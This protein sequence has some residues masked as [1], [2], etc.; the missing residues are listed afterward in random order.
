MNETRFSTFLREHKQILLLM[1]VMYIERIAVLC[2]LGPEYNLANDD[3]GYIGGGITF[4]A[5]G[6]V[7]IYQ[8]SPS[9]M[10]M[11]G[12]P[13]LL[14]L[15]TKLFGQARLYWV[16]VKLFWC[17]MGCITPFLVYKSVTLFAEKKYGLLA[18]AA[19]LLPNLA[20][21]DNVILTETPYYLCFTATIYCTLAMGRSRK[22]G[23]FAG[24]VIAYMAGLMLRPTIGIMPVFTAVYLLVKKF[25]FWQLLKRLVI[26]GLV[27][28]MFLVP[29]TVR[30]Y[31]HFDAFIPLTYGSG[32]PLLLGTYQGFGCPTDE[33]LDYE[34]N[35]E[36]VWREEYA[37]YLDEN[38][39][40]LDDGMKQYLTLEKDGIKAA[41]RMDAWWDTSPLTMLL[42]YLVIKPAVMV[43][44]TFYW[45]E[46][47]GVPSIVL[48]VLRVADFFLC[49][50]SVLL[51]FKR[52]QFRME[53]GFLAA[54]YWIY[55]YMIAM[56]YAFS[57][58]GETLMCLR[59]M[60][61]GIG[62]HLLVEEWNKHKA[63][64]KTS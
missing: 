33:E 40:P 31:E 55:I 9:A 28:M 30:N 17:L 14:G 15:F 37:E 29:W 48:D 47:F 64:K 43:V 41:Y 39:D 16:M 57:R 3:M 7:A 35:V 23:Y 20:W 18:A 26:N 38:G 2:I 36:Q 5:T 21:M 61:V 45:V 59:Y 10:I 25:P 50:V 49:C 4:A 53:V 54:V 56:T 1:L 19:F 60:I 46:L 11:P 6:T 42:S 13:V 34:T 51:C 52:K 44:K 8:V 27:L 63:V 32:N 12:M 24:Y 22:T 58:Y 62:L